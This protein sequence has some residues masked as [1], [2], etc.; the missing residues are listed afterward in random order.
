MKI[1]TIFGLLFL[2]LI[3][4]SGT[5]SNNHKSVASALQNTKIAETPSQFPTLNIKPDAKITSPLE[6]HINSQG[7][8]FASEGELGLIRLFDGNGTELAMDFMIADGE[9]MKSGPIMFSSTLTFAAVKT[10]KGT[11]VIHNNPGPGDGDE[12]GEET[13]FEIPVTF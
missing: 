4:C 11:L 8:W 13:S 3:S 7:L 9:W 6:I 5:N 2:L 10:K 12:A 1:S